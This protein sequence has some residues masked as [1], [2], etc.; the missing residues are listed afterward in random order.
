[1]VVYRFSVLENCMV[2][3]ETFLQQHNP[4]VSLE[5]SA[6]LAIVLVEKKKISP[7]WL[8]IFNEIMNRMHP[9]GTQSMKAIWGTPLSIVIN[10]IRDQ[11]DLLADLLK[12]QVIDQA[13]ELLD[14]LLIKH[15]A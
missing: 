14:S 4:P 10:L 7:S 5:E 1:M 12:L 15:S 2:N 13:I 3:Y 11:D 9:A 8:T 6:R